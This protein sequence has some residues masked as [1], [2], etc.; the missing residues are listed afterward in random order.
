MHKHLYRSVAADN[1]AILKNWFDV[2]MHIE[3]IKV[4]RR[5]LLF[6]GALLT[7]AQNVLMK[8]K[9][10]MGDSHTDDD[11]VIRV[12]NDFANLS[13]DPSHRGAHPIV[14]PPTHMANE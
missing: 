14:S 10:R 4:S 7:F 9:E 6:F 2:L 3:V 1:D 8:N 11:S 12:L 5:L 13:L